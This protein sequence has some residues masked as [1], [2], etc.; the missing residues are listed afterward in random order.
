MC[1]PNLGRQENLQEATRNFVISDLHI[2]F[3][4]QRA[5]DLV[6]QII[7]FKKPAKITILGDAI[8]FYPLSRFD[9]DPRRAKTLENEISEWK[10]F[11]QALR[12]AA[13]DADVCFIT[14]NHE[15]RLRKYIWRGAPALDGVVSVESLLDLDKYNFKFFEKKTKIDGIIYTHGS[16]IR[17]WSSYTARAMYEKYGASGLSGHSHRMGFFDTRVDA[18]MGFWRET[19]CLCDLNPEYV[20]DPDWHHGFVVVDHRPDTKWVNAQL[21][22]ISDKYECYLDGKLYRLNEF[23]RD[24][25]GR[26]RK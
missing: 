17:K 11:A 7:R 2:P 23:E 26:F 4:D 14:G 18:G 3:Q 24:E 16:L 15:D 6:L 9:H 10:I 25:R 8:D 19:G 20:D 21:I 13:P 12:R 22:E 5:V 1:Y